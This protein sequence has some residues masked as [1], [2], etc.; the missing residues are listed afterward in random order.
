MDVFILLLLLVI[1]IVQFTQK[2]SYNEKLNELQDKILSLQQLVKQSIQTKPPTVENP[3]PYTPPVTERPNVVVTDKIPETPKPA[4]PPIKP[5]PAEFIE[6]H[7]KVIA[8]PT[9]V[10]K[11]PIMASDT[12]PPQY[13]HP[14]PELSFF[15]KHPDLEKFIGENLINK[16]GI[17]ILVLAIGF[18]VKYAID[19]NW[20]GPV[21]RVGIGVLCGGILI[22]LAHAMRNSYRSF[23]SVLVGGGLAVLYFTI[24]LAYHQFHLFSQTTSFIILIVITCFAVALSLLYN[25]QELAV[26]ALLGGLSSPFMVSGNQ[27]NYHALFIYII[28]LNTGLLV[29]AYNKLWR[30]LNITAFVLTILVCAAVIYTLPNAANTTCFLYTSILYLLY[31]GINVANNVKENKTFIASDFTILLVNTGLYFGAGLYLLTAMQHPELRGLFSAGL[32]GINLVLSYIL[33]KN[34]KA[35]ANIIYLLIGITL[36]FL[37]LTAP[38]QLHGHNITLFWAAETVLLYWLYQKSKIELMKFTSLII[39]IAMLLSLLMDWINVYGSTTLA[40]SV[41]ANKGFITTLVVSVS[42]CLLATLIAKDENK[43]IYNVQIS[44]N[45]YKY[46]ALVLLFLSGFFEINHQ[47]LSRYPNTALNNLYLMLYAPA[48]VYAFYLLSKKLP[49]IKLNWRISAAILAMCITVYLAFSPQFFDV[50][51]SILVDGKISA[52]HFAAHWLGFVFVGLLFYQLAMIAKEHIP[53]VDMITWVLSAA[54]VLFLSL[55]VCLANNEL[56]YSRATTI[57]NMETNYIKVG[58]PILWGLA[59]FALMW[60]G[61]R[62]KVRTLRIVSLTLFTITLVKLFVFDIQ[63]IPPAGK[64]AAFFCLGVL[65]LIISF[66][67]QKVKKIIVEDAKPQPNE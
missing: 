29:I 58:L 59:S 20:I 36:T 15:D 42:S 1:L 14:E 17:A 45:L 21:G 65:L 33:F 22:G 5:V 57:N 4:A 11:R 18:F 51:Y 13:Q 2:N 43:E 64:I 38:I 26:I 8:A 37:S 16:I 67:Y 3:K 61:M 41:I 6:R 27:A 7:E 39:W 32:G 48:F 10:I 9:S 53:E 50:Q 19:N 24:T 63:N 25:K 28:I 35:D 62:N 66:M 54:I 60:L 47:F 56:F 40:L 23:S 12:P 30:I 52:M 46:T 55:E 31:F 34:K 44:I 49:A